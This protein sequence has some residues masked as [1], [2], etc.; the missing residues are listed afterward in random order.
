[1]LPGTRRSGHTLVEH[2]H[3]PDLEK[4]EGRNVGGRGP[5]L[6]FVVMCTI[7]LHVECNTIPGLG[8]ENHPSLQG[9]KHQEENCS[10]LAVLHT[11]SEGTETPKGGS[12]TVT[13]MVLVQDRGTSKWLL[14]GKKKVK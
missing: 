3:C 7:A 13:L 10:S 11:P 5:C 12:S 6:S 4:K 9:P 2:R 1:M 14:L 8:K